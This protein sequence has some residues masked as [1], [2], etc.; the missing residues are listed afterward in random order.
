MTAE[1]PKGWSKHND[2]K[3][4][5]MEE[6]LEDSNDDGSV[7][8]DADTDD[9]DE[10]TAMAQELEKGFIDEDSNTS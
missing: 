2:K 6:G 1:E 9:D 10:L 7:D 8:D 5:T 3:Q 4:K